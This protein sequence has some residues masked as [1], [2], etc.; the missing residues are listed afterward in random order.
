[1]QLTQKISHETKEGNKYVIAFD[2]INKDILPS[3]LSVPV[4]NV[5]LF[6]IGDTKP[7][8]STFFSYLASEVRS[9]LNKYNVILCYICDT[10]PIRMRNNRNISPQQYRHE[11]FVTLYEKYNDGTKIH[12][13]MIIEDDENGNHYVSL[14]S[15]I[16]NEIDVLRIN[17]YYVDEGK[18]GN[19]LQPIDS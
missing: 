8:T 13:P 12:H 9:Y 15:S 5:S 1:M 10:M 11:L 18:I 16:E 4:V 2:L 14:I 6:A 19:I 3:G 7:N 17:K